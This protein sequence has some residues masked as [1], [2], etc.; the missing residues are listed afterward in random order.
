MEGCL[1]N[2]SVR[3]PNFPPGESY[4]ETTQGL[5]CRNIYKLK[6]QQ[7][8]RPIIFLDFDGVLNTERHQ[9]RLAVEGKVAKDEWVPLFDPQAVANLQK[10]L[11][12]TDARIVITSTWRYIHSPGN[13]RKMWI[14]RGLPGKIFGFL[15]SDSFCMTRG[16]EIEDWL[17]DH[18]CDHFVII[19]D[20]DE[21]T[22]AQHD[23]LLRFRQT[24][25]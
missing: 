13:L 12:A 11:E 2:L 7:M 6:M 14:E 1:S 9:A 15:P 8:E 17:R 4:N 22:S 20:V 24:S 10:I 21:F 16:E 5:F 3:H 18:K 23:G 25:A 19:D